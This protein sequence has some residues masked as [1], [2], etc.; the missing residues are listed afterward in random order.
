[1]TEANIVTTSMD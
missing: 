1:M